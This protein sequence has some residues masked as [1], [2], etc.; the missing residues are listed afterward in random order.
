MNLDKS[1]SEED[2]TL[3]IDEDMSKEMA[4][5]CA[6]FISGHRGLRAVGICKLTNN[7]SRNLVYNALCA[8]EN[9]ESL[10]LNAKEH[11]LEVDL[12]KQ[13]GTIQ[14]LKVLDLPRGHLNIA[15]VQNL[16]KHTLCG[17]GTTEEGH[18]DGK[19]EEGRE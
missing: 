13:L 10:A 5:R 16:I 19:G 9:L 15:A 2:D 3:M 14:T 8:M 7:D 1:L 4:E 12:L 6:H 18:R 17:S 11:F